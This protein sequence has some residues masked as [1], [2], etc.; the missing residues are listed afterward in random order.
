MR[1]IPSAPFRTGSQAE[2]R[3]FD[4]L[5]RAFDDRYAAYHSLKPTRHPNKRFPEIDF[6]ICGPEGLYVLEIK[7]GRVSC[8]GGVWRYQ[9]RFGRVTQS[10]EGPFRQA[11]AALH[12]VMDT[13]RANLPA[14][15][16]NRLATSYGVVFPDC[17]WPTHGAE[18]NPEMLADRRRSRDLEDWL[19]SLFEHWQ[20]RCENSELLGDETLKTLHGF[21]RPNV[22]AADAVGDNGLSLLDRVS[23]AERRIERLTGDQMRM[24]DVAEA[25][26]RVLCEGGAGTGKTFLAERLARRWAES[27]MLVALVCRSPWLRHH[28]A[29]R[30]SIPHLT[31]SLIDSA[32][33][34]CRR[35]GLDC[36]DALIVDEG[37]DLFELTYLEALDEVLDGGLRTGRWCWFQDLNNQ[38]LT[39]GFDKNAKELLE[40]TDPV[41]IPLRINCRN[42]RIILEWIQETLD[43]DVGVRGAGAGP[44]I[45]HCTVTDPRESAERLTQE[46]LEIID[47]GGLAPG[48]VTILSPFDYGESCVALIRGQMATRIRR[49]DEYSM[50]ATADDKVGFAQIDEFKG[51]EN[52]AI[53]VVD[54][55]L[56]N[57][58]RRNSPEHYV[59]MTRARSV[60]SIIQAEYSNNL[61][62]DSSPPSLTRSVEYKERIRLR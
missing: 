4:R 13:L 56:P 50:R 7:G 21:L 52:Q 19:R 28:L 30:L 12:G 15:V 20:H 45:R 43:A 9:D 62:L 46:I 26:P 3:V 24:A 44:E 5:R 49:L 27:G 42:T 10:Q 34:D 38:A 35:A 32:G 25:N 37:Q 16:H 22:H 11:E 61:N 17:D 53:I 40:S 59:A 33:L 57:D 29:S 31:V 39:R 6:V 54:L 60:L 36:F 47:V 23:D 2:K 14:H 18:W 8:L 58:T 41:R 1:M 51:L 48:S 55:P